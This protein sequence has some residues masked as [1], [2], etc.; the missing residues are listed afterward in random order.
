MINGDCVRAVVHE[1]HNEG[2]GKHVEMKRKTGKDF[3]K[4]PGIKK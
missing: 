4:E 2:Y 3:P 1:V